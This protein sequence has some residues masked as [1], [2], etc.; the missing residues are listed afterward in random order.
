MPAEMGAGMSFVAATESDIKH[1]VFV[2]EESSPAEWLLVATF[3]NRG[4]AVEYAATK[5]GSVT[6]KSWVK[7]DLSDGQREE[8]TRRALGGE[9][10]AQLGHEFGLT[11][12]QVH[13]LIKRWRRKNAPGIRPIDPVNVVLD[14]R[15]SKPLPIADCYEIE[16]AACKQSL[17]VAHRVGCGEKIQPSGNDQSAPI[18]DGPGDD[19]D[20]CSGKMAHSPD[21]AVLDGCSPQPALTMENPRTNILAVLAVGRRLPVFSAADVAK[22][23]GMPRGSITGTLTKLV[24]KG[25]LVR[26]SEGRYGLPPKSDRTADQAAIEAHIAA[27]GTSSRPDFGDAEINAA[28]ASLKARG[29]SLVRLPSKGNTNRPY[30]LDHSPGITKAD[31]ISRTKLI[32]ANEKPFVGRAVAE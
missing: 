7:L 1:H 27:K 31:V 19:A 17:Q 4:L 26:I 21:G 9:D 5:N 13:D 20:G 12:G 15:N 16:P 11:V 32:V 14:P 25:Q 2:V 23:T 24:A 22:C 30:S 8:I 18:T 28:W 3:A 29:H 6:P 10:R